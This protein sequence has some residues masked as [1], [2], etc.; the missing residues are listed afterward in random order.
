MIRLYRLRRS[1]RRV[2]L[3]HS[4]RPAF[5]RRRAP[6]ARPRD[7]VAITSVDRDTDRVK[8]AILL[9]VRRVVADGVLCAQVGRNLLRDGVDL[10]QLAREEGAATSVVGQLLQQRLGLVL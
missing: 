3:I 7:D 8:G 4:R 6:V 2:L 1:A 10:R 5:A 9:G